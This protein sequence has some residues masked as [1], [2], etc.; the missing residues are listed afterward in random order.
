MLKSCG[1]KWCNQSLAR[2]RKQHCQHHASTQ[3]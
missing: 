1:R 3:R 2:L